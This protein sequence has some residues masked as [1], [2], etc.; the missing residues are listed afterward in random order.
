MCM[1][2]KQEIT[3]VVFLAKYIKKT[4]KCLPRKLFNSGIKAFIS[5]VAVLIRGASFLIRN[6]T[7]FPKLSTNTPS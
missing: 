4:M 2:A 7:I 3:K 5:L 1:K 6:K